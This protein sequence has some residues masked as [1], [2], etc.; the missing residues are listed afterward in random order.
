MYST[1]EEPKRKTRPQKKKRIVNGLVL[2]TTTAFWRELHPDIA[3]VQELA[4]W[5]FQ[6][7]D[8]PYYMCPNYISEKDAGYIPEEY[9]F[10]EQFDVPSFIG[11]KKEFTV[12]HTNK[13]RTKDKLRRDKG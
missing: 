4:K 6:D 1:L 8:L 5:T 2:F 12:D 7:I 11:L 10:A 3:A 13:M 9:N